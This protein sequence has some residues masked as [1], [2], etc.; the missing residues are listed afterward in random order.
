MDIANSH[1]EGSEYAKV[2][3][4]QPALQEKPKD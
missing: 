2:H 3:S 4:E 1:S